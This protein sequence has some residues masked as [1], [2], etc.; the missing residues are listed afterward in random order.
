MRPRREPAIAEADGLLDT[1]S[2]LL[3]IAQ[4]EAGAPQRLRRSI[5]RRSSRV[6][7]TYGGRRGFRHT[8]GWRSRT[9]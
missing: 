7:E 1:F 5:C 8:L 3:R 9:A 4:I 6:G 2:A